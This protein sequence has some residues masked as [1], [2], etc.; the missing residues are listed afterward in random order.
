MTIQSGNPAVERV[1]ERE[2]TYTLTASA[3]V[4]A[5]GEYTQAVRPTSSTLTFQFTR[6]D[7]EWR[8]AY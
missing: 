3:T 8:I 7:G 6:E 1:G 2:L 4:D 5:D